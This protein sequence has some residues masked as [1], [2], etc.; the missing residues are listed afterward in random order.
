MNAFDLNNSYLKSD[1]PA[2]D[3]KIDFK[4]PNDYIEE[5]AEDYIIK[6]DNSMFNIINTVPD[7]D[8]NNDA[9]FDYNTV[10]TKP[11]LQKQDVTKIAN[12]MKTE[13]IQ[14]KNKLSTNITSLLNYNNLI[15]KITEFIQELIKAGSL[16]EILDVLMKDNNIIIVLLF[17][18]ILNIII[19]IIF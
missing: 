2:I 17:I 9:Y 10:E 12:T 6:L 19:Q 14:E 18:V 15:I 1:Y 11:I 3:S 8:I 4:M 5:N 7:T 13:L 16:N